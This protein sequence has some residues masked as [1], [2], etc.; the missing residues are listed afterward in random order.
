[1]LNYDVESTLFCCSESA[2]VF[3]KGS[4]QHYLHPYLI[5]LW[6]QIQTVYT[7]SQLIWRHDYPQ[8]T[9][10]FESK[11]IITE[12]MVQLLQHLSDSLNRK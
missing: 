11:E 2:A 8:G 6:C 12:R 1:M 3:L 10:N 4:K 7:C 9:M 5:Y